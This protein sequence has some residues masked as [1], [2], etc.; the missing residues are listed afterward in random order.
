M[1]TQIHG[2]SWMHP[3]V[4]DIESTRSQASRGDHE[5]GQ[6]LQITRTRK[7][8]LYAGI[9]ICGY[10]TVGIFSTGT[11]PRKREKKDEIP[12][13]EGKY[14]RV[15]VSVQRICWPFWPAIKVPMDPRSVG[16]LPASTGACLRST[17]YPEVFTHEY[18]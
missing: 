14:L 1:Y 2:T 9:C 15:F 18:R 16:I 10:R 11:G 7:Y 17:K 8:E 13:P 12:V 4:P 5:Y 3:Q 6:Y